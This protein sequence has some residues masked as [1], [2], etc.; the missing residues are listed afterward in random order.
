MSQPITVPQGD[1]ARWRFF[2][3]EA[4]KSLATAERFRDTPKVRKIWLDLASSEIARAD[5]ARF[6]K[7]A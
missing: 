6:P 1:I 7:A 2:M 5:A 4:A 3:A